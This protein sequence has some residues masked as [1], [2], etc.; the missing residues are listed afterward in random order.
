[1]KIFRRVCRSLSA[2]IHFLF[3]PP[4]L[5]LA[6]CGNDTPSGIGGEGFGIVRPARGDT[7][8]LGRSYPILYALN[9]WA[10]LLVSTDE[11]GSWDYIS[12]ILA[13]Q[14]GSRFFHWFVDA[15]TTTSARL[16]LISDDSLLS[17]T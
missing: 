14:P 15:D 9:G 10:S 12:H 2:A 8:T 6:G 1:M 13:H 4:I 11:G 3:L 5:S 16:R 17:S 7:L